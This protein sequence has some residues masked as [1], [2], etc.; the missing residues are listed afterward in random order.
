MA[1]HILTILA[2]VHLVKIYIKIE[3]NPCSGLRKV[4]NAILGYIVTY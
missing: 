3:A 1:P 4:I 2:A